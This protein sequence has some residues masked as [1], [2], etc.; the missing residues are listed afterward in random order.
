MLR[1]SDAGALLVDTETCSTDSRFGEISEAPPRDTEF[2]VILSMLYELESVR[3][4]AKF[5]AAVLRPLILSTPR[6]RPDTPGCSPIRL[7][8]LLFGTGSSESEACVNWLVGRPISVSRTDAWP[9]TSTV[10]LTLPTCSVK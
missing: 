10:S 2:A 9:V 6:L 4:P 5:T 1:P 8:R 3:A 7:N